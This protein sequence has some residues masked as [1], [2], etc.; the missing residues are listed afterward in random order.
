MMHVFS[1]GMNIF[2]DATEQDQEI[3]TSENVSNS[4]YY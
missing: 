2:Q 4:N 1:D 3:Q